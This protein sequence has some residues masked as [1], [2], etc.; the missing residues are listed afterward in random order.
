MKQ[1]ST[2]LVLAVAIALCAPA[3]ASDPD[4]AGIQGAFDGFKVALAAKDEAAAK[5]TWHPAG[6]GENITGGSG[7]SGSDVFKQGSRKGWWL[8]ADMKKLRQASRSGP[9]IVPCVIWSDAKQKA[10]DAVDVVV[11]WH[12]G[13]WLLLGGGES[14]A[15][16]DALATRWEKGEFKAPAGIQS[17]TKE[18]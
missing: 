2:L 18:K 12:D 7:L 10:V 11:V 5:A 14:S 17:P 9:W 1:L 13:K 6:W 3:A 8:K 4:V 15:E 16:V